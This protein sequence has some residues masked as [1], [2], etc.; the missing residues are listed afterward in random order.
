MG[1]D[2]KSRRE[3]WNKVC[4]ADGRLCSYCRPHRGSNSKFKAAR[5]DRYK[6]KRVQRPEK[7]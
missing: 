7:S 1:A 6:D 3:H 5:P 4:E 2:S